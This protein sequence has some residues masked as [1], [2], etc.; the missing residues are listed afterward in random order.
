M[1]LKQFLLLLR[2]VIIRG[3]LVILHWLEFVSFVSAH[4]LLE[5]QCALCQTKH[6]GTNSSLLLFFFSSLLLL[7]L[8]D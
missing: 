4:H 6:F 5:W 7:L 8:L 3:V 1:I 2:E